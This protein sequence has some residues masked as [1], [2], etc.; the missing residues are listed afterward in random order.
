DATSSQCPTPF[1]SSPRRGLE[2][3][4]ASITLP[5]EAD[6][7]SCCAVLRGSIGR[8][9]ERERERTMTYEDRDSKGRRTRQMARA[10]SR[11]HNARGGVALCSLVLLW[12]AS[13]GATPPEPPAVSPAGERAA[14]AAKAPKLERVPNAK[15][16]EHV[17]Q[18]RPLHPGRGPQDQPPGAAVGLSPAAPPPARPAAD[19]PAHPLLQPPSPSLA[20][21]RRE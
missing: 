5:A 18:Q 17:G 15:P 6:A 8:P 13:S 4:E 12:A 19:A 3:R 11:T 20:E 10:R 2:W 7:P 14:P 21:A 16:D 9:R 1:P